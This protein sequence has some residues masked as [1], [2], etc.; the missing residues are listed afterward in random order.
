L[1][2]WR[3][4]IS[5]A[6]MCQLFC[7]F[8]TYS[9]SALFAWALTT[10]VW[11]VFTSIKEKK[12]NPLF[13]VAA[14]SFLTCLGLL[15]PQLVQRGGVVASSAIAQ[16]SDAFRL[17]LHDIGLSMLKAHPWLG[18][19]YNNYM[20]SFH[21]F[22]QGQPIPANYLHN[23]YLHLG[24][25]VGILGLASFL[26]FCFFILKK[27][28]KNRNDPAV[29]TCSCIIGAFLAIG[30]VDHYPLCDQASRI[31]FFLAAGVISVCPI[32]R[33]ITRDEVA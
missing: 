9:R 29:L 11:V 28:W 2:K 22:I 20:L 32:R 13:W 12:L 31:I 1:G 17:T 14:G 4:W 8:I 23:I 10:A 26:L 6:I 33:I 3:R 21:N 18:V 16:G 24:V 5:L 19:G 30:L 25:E 7:L 27:G 15:Y